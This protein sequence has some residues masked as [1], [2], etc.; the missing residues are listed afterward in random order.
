MFPASSYSCIRF[1]QDGLN[2]L[3]RPR[4][5]HGHFRLAELRRP[6]S[7]RQG[8]GSES[9]KRGPSSP[10]RG[11]PRNSGRARRARCEPARAYRPCSPS[12][13]HPHSSLHVTTR[14]AARHARRAVEQRVPTP[15]RTL[16]TPFFIPF[17]VPDYHRLSYLRAFASSPAQISKLSD[18]GS[19]S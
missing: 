17:F 3:V 14:T 12:V 19:K 13:S 6:G 4:P 7:G 2:H 15:A 5:A 11:A 10:S 9:L 18:K 16:D 8:D 1:E